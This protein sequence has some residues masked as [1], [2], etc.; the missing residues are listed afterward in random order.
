MR[1]G[2]RGFTLVEMMVAVVCSAVVVAGAFVLLTD[3]QKA[4]MR[5]NAA[6]EVVGQARVALEI[7]A[8]DIR[9][10]GDSL[11]LLPAKCLGAAAHA[12]A[13]GL[14]PA[15]LDAH[16]WRLAIARNAWVDVDDDGSTFGKADAPPPLNRRFEQNGE[17]VVAFRFVPTAAPTFGD[18]RRGV[19]GRIERVVNPFRFPAGTGAEKVTVLL[20]QVVLDDRMRTDPANPAS[21]DA[22]FANALFMY[23]VMTKSGEL[24]GD[25]AITKRETAL[26]D[27]FL[28]PPLRFFAAKAPSA[29]LTTPPFVPGGYTAEVVGLRADE[30]KTESKILAGGTGSLDPNV[31]TSDLRFVLDRDRIRAVR[32]AFKVADSRERR[33]VTD[34]VDLDGNVA[35]GTAPLFPFETTIELK[36]L[37]GHVGAI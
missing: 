27:E 15:V 37:A 20:D 31:P 12:D 11:D 22:R 33:G 4:V 5:Q 17:N 19:L 8:R 1:R 7:L 24:Y 35:N 21:A 34:G 10:A 13:R 36:V 26:N 3:V 14:C 18:G 6:N 2:D 23:R 28:S 9:S 29:Y 32:V 30:T 25:D 16:P